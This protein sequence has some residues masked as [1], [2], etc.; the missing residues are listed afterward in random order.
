MKNNAAE[1]RRRGRPS[2][3]GR[4]SQLVALTLPV[5]VLRGLR[6]VDRD[7]ARAIVRVFE[8]AA[9]PADELAE[10]LQPDAELVKIADR[11]SL[12]VVNSAVIRSLPGVSIVPLDGTRAFLALEPGRGVSDLELAVIDRLDDAVQP[13]ER[14]A[15]EQLRRQLRAWRRD[16]ALRFH[17]RAIIV[18]ETLAPARAQGI[19]TPVRAAAQKRDNRHTVAHPDSMPRARLFGDVEE[20]QSHAGRLRPP[21]VP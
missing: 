16:P 9:N 1:R 20:R 13:R 15:L 2:K 12:I 19:A 10:D 17:G 21:S 3:F 14:Q 6:R 8:G 7:L 4:P 5:D 11:R 18:V